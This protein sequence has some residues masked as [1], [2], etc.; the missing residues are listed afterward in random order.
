MDIMVLGVAGGTGS[1]KTT[2]TRTPQRAFWRPD[3]RDQPRQLLQAP[4]PPHLRGALQ[5]QLRPPGRLRHRPDGA[6]PAQLKSGGPVLCPV[7]DF[8]QH[9]RSADLLEIRP[10][11]VILVEGILIFTSPELCNLMDIKVFGHRRRRAHSPPH[12]AGRK[13]RGRTLD[14]VVTQYSPP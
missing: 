11:P 1:G 7:Y 6:A 8:S 3:Q 9:N 2:L 14:S 5:D 4:G 13:K 10:A 12:R